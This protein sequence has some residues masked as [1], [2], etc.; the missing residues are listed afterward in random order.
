[1]LTK[2]IDPDKYSHSRYGIGF[3]SRSLLAVPNFDWGKNI[4]IFGVDNSSLVHID[5]KK[6][7]ILVLGKG[8]T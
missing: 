1:M 2:N 7:Y 3:D 6:I 4:V 5:N 8:P